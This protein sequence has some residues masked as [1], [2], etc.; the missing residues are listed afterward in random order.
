M[1]EA[2]VSSQAQATSSHQTQD[3]QFLSLLAF[4]PEETEAGGGQEQVWRRV[5]STTTQRVQDWGQ[6]GWQSCLRLP[7]QGQSLG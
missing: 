5:E 3:P 2:L 6:R 4:D 1:C 7:T